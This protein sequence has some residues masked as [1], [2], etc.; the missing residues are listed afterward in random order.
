MTQEPKAAVF[1]EPDRQSQSTNRALSRVKKLFRMRETG[2]V[3]I[4][5]ALFHRHVVRLAL[6]PDLGEHAGDGDGLCS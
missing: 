6:F 2:L 5:L 1:D 4:I 3:L